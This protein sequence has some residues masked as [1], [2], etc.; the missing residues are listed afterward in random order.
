MLEKNSV[1]YLNINDRHKKEIFCPSLCTIVFNNYHYAIACLAKRY[2]L[3]VHF[4]LRKLYAKI[5]RYRFSIID[6]L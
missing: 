6:N 5:A 3:K 1:K 4:R 2:N